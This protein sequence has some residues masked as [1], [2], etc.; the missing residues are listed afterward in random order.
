M[1]TD[2]KSEIRSFTGHTVIYGLGVVLYKAIAF[3]LLPVYLKYLSPADY[4]VL[5]TVSVTRELTISLFAMGIPSAFLKY[6]HSKFGRDSLISTAFWSYVL[7]QILAPVAMVLLNDQFSGIILNTREYATCFSILALNISLI[8]FRM[9][10]LTLYQA[11]NR[12]LKYAVTNF[13]VALVTLLGNIYFVVFLKMGVEGV[14]WGN[15]SGGIMGGCLVALDVKKHLHFQFEIRILKK[16]LRYGIP[17]AMSTLPLNLIFMND[18]YFLSHF[19]NLDELG[20]YALA[21][22]FSRLLMVFFITPF[23]LSWVPFIL[24]KSHSA[25]AKAL[26]AKI[27]SSFYYMGVNILVVIC[28]YAPIAVIVMSPKSYWDAYFLIPILCFSVLIYGIGFVFR[29]GILV[30]EKTGS[31]TKIIVAGLAVNVIS[32]LIFVP[33]FG[34]YGAAVSLALSFGF[35]SIFSFHE[36]QRRLKIDYPLFKMVIIT[37]VAMFMVILY[38]YFLGVIHQ[39]YVKILSAVFINGCFIVLNHLTGIVDLKELSILLKPRN[40]IRR[41]K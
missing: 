35:T 20:R 21:S 38:Y 27:G 32:N 12:S 28:L 14:L 25:N 33:R 15:F 4:G 16:M 34:M 22:K 40:I 5:E 18:R 19:S 3:I 17:I 29:S 7:L 13:L 26:F 2:N 24:E 37:L 11:E 30:S 39:L 8:S 36:G 9:I 31:I 6:F 23:Q 10:P 1:Q 41:Y